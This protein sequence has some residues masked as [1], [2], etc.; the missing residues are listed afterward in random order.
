MIL[1]T[2]DS[3]C[4]EIDALP[5]FLQSVARE[6][7]QQSQAEGYAEIF[8]EACKKLK[9]R[10]PEVECPYIPYTTDWRLWFRGFTRGFTEGYIESREYV[11]VVAGRLHK[12]GLPFE[13]ILEATGISEEKLKTIVHDVSAET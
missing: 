13:K 9:K 11:F 3:D 1:S 2:T 12:M 4:P 7:F 6:L 8:L 5:E 10:I